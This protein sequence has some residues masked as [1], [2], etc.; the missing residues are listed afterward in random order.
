MPGAPFRIM[1]GVRNSGAHGY[2]HKG[3]AT[4][5]IVGAIRSVLAGRIYVS[6]EATERLLHGLVDR[7]GRK[8]RSGAS[9]LSD[10]ELLVFESIGDGHSTQ[11]I[12]D[13]MH[14]SPKT[15]DTYRARIK[16]KL[17][18]ESSRELVQLATRHNLERPARKR[19][20]STAP[21][22]GGGAEPV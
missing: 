15:I 6:P 4:G 11:S 12:A 19:D 16:V 17:N 14:V 18:V 13:M 2:I 20:G 22:R 1:W 5:E 8:S 10:R 7:R 3:R 21:G 9:C